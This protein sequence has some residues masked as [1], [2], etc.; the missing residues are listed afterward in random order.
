MA[1]T[2]VIPARF[3]A[4]RFPGKPLLRETG[5]FL[6]QHVYERVQQAK[7]IDRCL[8]ATDDARIFDAAR[9]FDAEAIMTREDHTSGTDRIAEVMTK[10]GG[11]DSDLVLNVQGD[12]PEIEPAYLDR[13]VNRMKT[14]P[15]CPM[16]TLAAP[17]PPD[18][19]P[20]DPNSVKV[21]KNQSGFALYFS[22]ARIPYCRDGKADAYPAAWLLHIGVY[23]LRRAFLLEFARWPTGQLERIE[24][25]EQLR[26]LERGVPIVVE[27]VERS[28]VG[29]DTPQDYAA[30]VA[31]TRARSPSS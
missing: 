14:A 22:R 6:L 19:N 11:S 18:A 12:E 13:L 23:A 29:I 26:A 9:S 17:F 27:T 24:K 21:V 25:L 28:W 5:K 3:A 10:L 31:R 30:F 16:G 20:D 7:S 8:I 1:V 2:A 15:D 4:V